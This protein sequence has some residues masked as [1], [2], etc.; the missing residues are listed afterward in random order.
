MLRP[1]RITVAL[2]T[3]A[4][5]G[6][7]TSLHVWPGFGVAMRRGGRG[8]VAWHRRA[9]RRCGGGAGAT[10]VGVSWAGRTA[11]IG[12]VGTVRTP[13]P[14]PLI[15]VEVVAPVVGAVVVAPGAVVV[16][17]PGAV[18]VV[19]SGTSG[20]PHG[21]VWST[22]RN[23][24]SAVWPT[25]SSAFSRSFTPGRST[26]IV[27]PCRCTSG[28]A[29]PRPSTRW[30]MMSTAVSS[31]EVSVPLTG[32]R[33]IEIPPWRSR[34]SAGR[35]DDASVHTNV[36]TMITTVVTSMMICL[37]TFTTSDSVLARLQAHF[38]LSRCRGRRCRRPSRP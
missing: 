14:L 9:G 28:S 25:C 13:A 6:V 29:M 31:A 36:P 16:V 3:F 32:N 35:F 21:N 30:R 17:A 10:V 34:P 20:V 23:R 1:G 12:V 37:R 26:T 8:R 38:W 24:S 5:D 19:D 22:G 4:V 15:V 27:L 18:V 11:A 33:T 2:A 7:S